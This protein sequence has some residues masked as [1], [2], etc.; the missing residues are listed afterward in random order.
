MLFV[1]YYVMSEWSVPK[2][3]SL[4]V[5]DVKLELIKK[6]SRRHCFSG[7]P[8]LQVKGFVST[9]R[10]CQMSVRSK[11]STIYLPFYKDFLCATAFPTFLSYFTSKT[12]LKSPPKIISSHSKVKRRSKTFSKKKGS[13]LFGA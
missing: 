5:V 2:P 1:K 13:S 3:G 10:R 6:K 4:E 9:F 8:F 12:R 7:F 11:K